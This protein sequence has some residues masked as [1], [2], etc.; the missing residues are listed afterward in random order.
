LLNISSFCVDTIPVSHEESICDGNGIIYA[1]KDNNKF[2]IT[3]KDSKGNKKEN[4]GE[5]LKINIIGENK[6]IGIVDI[7]DNNN[8]TYGINYKFE[9]LN[10]KSKYCNIE[11]IYGNKHLKEVHLKFHL[12]F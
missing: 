4:G 1:L 7:K 6:E 12:F 2:I 11:I 3:L 5:K 8:G 9:D 10:I